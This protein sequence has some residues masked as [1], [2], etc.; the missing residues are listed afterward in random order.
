MKF[1]TERS[2]I[3]L[4]L[5][6]AAFFALFMAKGAL[7]APPPVIDGA[8][9]DTGRALARL[10]LILG[11]ERPHPVDSA[12]NDAVRERL[13]AEIEAIGYAP[14]IRDDFACRSSPR[15]ATVSCARVRNVV[16]RAGPSGGGAVMIASHYDSVSAGPGAGDDG[17]GVAAALEIA[18]ILKKRRPV[19]PVLFLMTDG[20]E[21]GLLGAA[22]FVRKD[23]LAKTIAAVINVEARGAAGRALLFQT[24]DPNGRDIAA[25]AQRAKA[26]AGNS[27]ATDIYKMLPNDTDMS[28]FLALGP[29]AINL[30]FS[31]RVELYHTPL[32]SL[33]HLDQRSVAHLGASGL[34][35]LDGFLS[36]DAK[37]QS[38]KEGRFVFAD[39]AGRFLIVLPQAAALAMILAGLIASAA[40]FA[41]IGGPA[42]I[43]T[44]LAPVA[45]AA[46]AG[47]L[48]FGAIPL[49][50]ALRPETS[51]W[52]A[53]PDFTRAVIY[54]SAMAGGVAAMAGAA[55][56]DRRRLLAAAWFWFSL[57]GAAAY[58]IAPGSAL[59]TGL[60][61]ALFACAALSSLGAP[62]ILAPV[63]SLAA[64]AALLLFATALHDA[65][66]GLGLGAAAPSSVTAALLF[67][68]TAPI[69]TPAGKISRV[70]VM[71][72]A[73]A[74]LAA[75]ILALTAPAYSPAAPRALNIHHILGANP[76]E[77]FWSLGSSGDRAPPAMTAIAPF[78]RR[79]IEGLTDA[80]LAAPAPAHDGR[81][82]GV[83]ILSDDAGAAGRTVS[84]R[85]TANGADEIIVTAPEDA[86]LGEVTIGGET[87]ALGGDGEKSIRCSGR[88]CATFEAR[89]VVGPQRAEWTILGVRHGLGPE[90][91]ALRA[92]R[93]N[94]A[95][96]VHVGDARIVISKAAI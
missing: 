75:I 50:G 27:L 68:L 20:E 13:I 87:F 46:I 70:T 78:E 39:A 86:K 64:I 47:A 5:F 45:A 74:L 32:D 96:P 62:R 9:F 6:A 65:E 57:I 26:P 85:F 58:A 8:E 15:W 40:A 94:W 79:E 14:E 10:A 59:L 52:S 30:A 4:L 25:Y 72:P 49:I 3:A 56:A 83:E 66:V 38:K 36:A 34:A 11:D 60:P 22:S 43:R 82:A 1:A 41:K 63:S 51:F 73:I 88:A 48:A 28:E 71:A 95:V 16:F 92:A 54:L 69:I 12:A 19:K 91:E 35:A 2:A 76:G 55:D 80:R 67:M 81:A 61:A 33:R 84:V 93:P 44:A 77:A 37:E 7:T 17:A 29:D 42:P 90:S 18:A 31:D 21:P 23:P 24:S 89:F 53:R